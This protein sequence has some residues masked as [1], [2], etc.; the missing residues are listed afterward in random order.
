MTVRS[1]CS[2]INLQENTRGGVLIWYTYR[3]K[4]CN[5]TKIGLA[6]GEADFLQNTS[7]HQ[8]VKIF[9]KITVVK[10]ISIYLATCC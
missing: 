2:G 9:W 4:A 6:T 8:E 3:N 1:G 7:R 10:V 5:F